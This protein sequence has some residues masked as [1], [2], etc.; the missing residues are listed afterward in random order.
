MLI[1]FII[2]GAHYNDNPQPEVII[3]SCHVH[4]KD[5]NMFSYCFAEISSDSLGK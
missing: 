4:I 1:C 2:S 5:V 3:L